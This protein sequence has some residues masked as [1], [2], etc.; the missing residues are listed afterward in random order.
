M[1]FEELNSAENV[2]I[3][4]KQTIRALKEDSVSIIYLADDIDEHIRKEIFDAIGEAEVH[5]VF[6]PTKQELG[7][8]CG[9]DVPC[10]CAAVLR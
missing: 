10:A 9:I 5:L 2:V 6:V 4:T 3:G 1:L 7:S 8:E